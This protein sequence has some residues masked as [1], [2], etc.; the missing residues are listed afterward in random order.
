MQA[1][2]VCGSNKEFWVEDFWARLLHGSDIGDELV[3][4]M[5]V[6]GSCGVTDG[7]Y[8]CS[9]DRGHVGNHIDLND[10]FVTFEVPSVA[11]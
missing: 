11:S 4:A 8:R 9:L 1:E 6:S 3:T 10:R 7:E 5:G 2:E